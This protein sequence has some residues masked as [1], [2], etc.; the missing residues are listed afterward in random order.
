MLLTGD[1]MISRL[2]IFCGEGF[3]PYRNLA[4]EKH[5]L[6]TVPEGTLRL[7]LWQNDNTVVVGANQNPYAECDCASLTA[8]GGFVARRLSGGGAVFH[9]KGNLNFTFLCREE[10]YDIERH[11]NII[12]TACGYANIAAAVSGR[13][14]VLAD[15]KKFSGNAFYHTA[16]RAFH[17]GTLLVDGD[18]DK[19]AR[20]LTPTQEKL[21]AKG[22]RSVRSR[23][24][25]LREL[26]PTLT[27]SLMAQFMIKAAES[28]C[29]LTAE[30]L[31]KL[32]EKAIE[33]DTA[34][35]GSWDYIYGKTPPFSL[36]CGKR[37]AW[38]EIEINLSLAHGVIDAAKVYTDAL[39][40]TLAA[41]LEAALSGVRWSADEIRRTLQ[42][43]FDESLAN[44]LMSI[45]KDALMP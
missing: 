44:D 35:F 3:D 37:F 30:I 34:L 8:D 28:V 20:Y 27:P 25:N 19:I 38:G 7:Y 17:H 4:I 9:D 21:R 11:F 15:G 32:D 43:A 40:H 24:V 23:V 5:L 29:Y 16:G 45:I 36:R 41:R 13:N 10:D 31:S 33:K 18:T 26:N 39:D 6:D 1:T 42:N 22:V 2:E 12:K 14:D